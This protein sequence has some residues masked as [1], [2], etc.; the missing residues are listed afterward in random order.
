[1]EFLKI[2]RFGKVRSE[3]LTLQCR[4]Y[5]ESSIK[6]ELNL[7]IELTTLFNRIFVFLFQKVHRKMFFFI[8]QHLNL[9]FIGMKDYYQNYRKNL[10]FFLLF[11]KLS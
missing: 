5:D 10:F 6:S 9:H 3:A 8:F 4:A 1:M 11:L 2:M 7:L